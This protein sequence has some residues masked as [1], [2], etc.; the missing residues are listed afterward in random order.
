MHT[1]RDTSETVLD[2]L[3]IQWYS[4]HQVSIT[5]SLPSSLRDYTRAAASKLTFYDDHFQ[6]VNPVLNP[7]QDLVLDPAP[8]IGTNV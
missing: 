4:P 3:L 7:V 6:P 2:H 8:S 5:H 1:D